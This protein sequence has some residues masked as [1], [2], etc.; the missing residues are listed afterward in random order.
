MPPTAIRADY[1]FAP[2]GTGPSYFEMEIV[3][4][5][6]SD[7]ESDKSPVVTIGLCGEFADLVDA[8]PGWRYQSLGYHSD[9]GT[10]FEGETDHDYHTMSTDQKFGE[11]DVIGCGVD[12]EHESYYFTFNGKLF[13]K[14]GLNEIER[15]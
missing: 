5:K 6:V 4:C 8:H 2:R 14:Q 11:N 9:D 12:W 10:I 15:N 1:P 3:N 13:S 7:D